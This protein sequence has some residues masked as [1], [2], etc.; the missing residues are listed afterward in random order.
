MSS[1]P[2]IYARPFLERILQK[3]VATQVELDW[4]VLHASRVASDRALKIP[5]ADVNALVS[6]A[7]LELRELDVKS[8]AQ[9]SATEDIRS[10]QKAS[11]YGIIGEQKQLAREK[12]LQQRQL[13]GS[14]IDNK[15][16]PVTSNT[17]RRT[18][19]P[20]YAMR[21]EKEPGSTFRKV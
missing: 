18:S 19:R 12:Q 16:L 8:I 20:R 3:R 21:E 11:K 13:A 10:A 15:R 4:D 5:E 14:R 6:A 1:F 2:R 9:R 7:R 17:T